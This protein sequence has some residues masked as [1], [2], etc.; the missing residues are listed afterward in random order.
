MKQLTQKLKDGVVSVI[1]VPP[2]RLTPGMVLVRNHF[3]LI[4]AGTEGST[5]SA[6]RKSLIGKARERPQQVRQVLEIFKQQGPTQT[7]RAV[8]K[9]LDTYSPL[10]Y[11]SAGEVIEVGSNVRGFSA[12]DL[13]ACAGA[14]YANHAEIVSVPAHLCVKLP[15]GADL[16]LAAY[17]TLGAI[18]LQG[19]RQAD[20]RLGETC[21]VIGLGLLGQLTGLM[22]KA[23]GIKVI[24]LDINPRVVDIAAGH[25]ADLAFDSEAPGLSE[26][27]AELTDGIG[28]DAVII[29]A[30]THSLQPINLAGQLLRPRGT[31]VVV[32]AVPTGFDREP[33]FYRKELSL[34]MSCSYG[35]GRY[36]PNY[37]EKGLDYPVGYVRWTE[38][39]NMRAFQSL[40]H[41]G[42][43]DLSYLTT[44]R[45]KLDEAPAAYDLILNRN[46]EFLGI[47]LEYD[48]AG[49]HPERR[50]DM[51]PPKPR[52][53]EPAGRGISFIGA[54]SYAMSHLL[55]N[56]AA[57]DGVSLAGVVTSTGTSS[58]TVAE[59]FGFRFCSADE[60]DVL[61]DEATDT[62]FIATRHDSHAEFVLKALEKGK[63]VFVEKPLCLTPDER[64]AIREV[65]E[66]AQLQPSA[67]LLMVGFN[68]R[69]APLA[70]RLKE[71]LG[72]G[73]MCLMYRVNAGPIPPDSWIQDVELGGG[74]IVGEICHFV[75]L[76][77]YL[78]ESS[79]E[80]VYAAAMADPERTEDTLAI[81]L[82]FVDGS[83]GTILYCANGA[84]SL[85][86]EYLEVYRAGIT[87]ILRDFREL[88]IHGCG[89]PKRERL[90]NQDKGQ[91]EMVRQFVSATQGRGGRVIPFADILAS[92]D[93][94]FAVKESLRTRSAVQIDG[95]RVF[96]PER[97]SRFPDSL[98]PAERRSDSA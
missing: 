55:P 1:E 58:R 36:D 96:A 7:Y 26:I 8:M 50:I 35:P 44:H 10:G 82:S 79:P 51:A 28:A 98:L 80:S 88:E 37:E 48:A 83:V 87:G 25:C 95:L 69:Y 61:E 86:K 14:G 17:N 6:A 91:K 40:V 57:C 41:S 24:G 18:A 43:I 71:A 77:I 63:H 16:S 30:A 94:T 56:V 68:R 76:M 34:K 62:V 75:D 39:R 42:R 78:T 29:T 74:R 38:N 46:E 20:L 70:V 60:R 9:K 31:V 15:A 90:F 65:Y 22:L 47:L 49:A 19:I 2:P 64:D 85:A 84:K 12:G 27:V 59:K 67:P 32:G 81:T 54:G 66:R 52:R 11:S 45:F 33:H 3:S 97:E 92:T 93:T 23:S 53:D 13:V 21:V 89:R 5:V 4:S 73:P 72:A